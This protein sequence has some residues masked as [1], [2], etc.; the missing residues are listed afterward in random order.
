MFL[1]HKGRNYEDITRD[2]RLA[3]PINFIKGISAGKL[4]SFRLH[5]VSVS[6]ERESVISDY[7]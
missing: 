1:G 6:D 7:L 5:F 2:R 3:T 4:H